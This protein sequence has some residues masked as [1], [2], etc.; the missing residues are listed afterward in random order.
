[1]CECKMPEGEHS[2]RCGTFH[3]RRPPEALM[4][5]MG[6]IICSLLL[7]DVAPVFPYQKWRKA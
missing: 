6:N 4:P 1:M 3:C 7:S 5:E 2:R